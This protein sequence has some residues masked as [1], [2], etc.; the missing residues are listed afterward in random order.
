MNRSDLRVPT[1]PLDEELP[2]EAGISPTLEALYDE[3][4]RDFVRPL[5]DSLG[6]SFERLI[7]LV[8][9]ELSFIPL[10]ART[11]VLRT[12]QS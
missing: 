2:V 5:I 11:R 4:D 3:L 1:L 6:E 12:G 10:S 8:H 7:V 9:A